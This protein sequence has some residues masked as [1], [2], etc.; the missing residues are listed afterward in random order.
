MIHI[1]CSGWNYRHWRSAF[2]PAG[3]PVKHWFAYYAKH[4]DTVEINASFYRL[5]KPS[6]FEAWRKQA[7]PG[8]CYTVKAPRFITHMHKLKDEGALFLKNVRHLGDRLGPILYQL[9]PRWKYNRE[10]L[11]GFLNSRPKD[12]VH[13][14]EFRD[15][16]WINDEA[17]ALLERHGASFCAHDMPGALTPRWAAGPVA[18]VRFHGSGKRYGGDY[19]HDVL[20]SWRDWMLD[21]SRHGRD[22]WAFFNNDAE[23]KAITDAA[24]LRKLL[25]L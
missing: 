8:F 17:L 25:G 9:P 6:S 15:P 22:V 2:Y 4:F 14:F 3:L 24:E 7:P 23:A 1:G 19:P 10:R 18:Y 16:S 11:E 12:L 5:P 13:V 20:E 21:Q